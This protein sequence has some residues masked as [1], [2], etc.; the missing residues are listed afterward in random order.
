MDHTLLAASASCWV[1]MSAGEEVAA[2]TYEIVVTGQLSE[3]L[4][5][6]IGARGFE[7]RQG[8]TAI[9]VDVIDQSHLHGILTWLQDRNIAIERVNPV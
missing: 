6:D 9:I 4:V 2:R 5:S 1:V 7:L 3:D 8:K